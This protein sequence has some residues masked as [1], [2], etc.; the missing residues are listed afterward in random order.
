M[1]RKSMQGTPSDI[2]VS[3]DGALVMAERTGKYAGQLGPFWCGKE[4]K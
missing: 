3:L 1:R 2:Q 4:G